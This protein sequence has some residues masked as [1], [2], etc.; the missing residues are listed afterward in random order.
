L[1]GPI[2]STLGNLAKLERL[3]LYSNQLS[4]AIPVE[5]GNLSGLERIWLDGNQLSDVVPLEVAELGGQIQY[6][7]GLT[8]CVFVP[9]G[10]SGLS[11]P[12]NQDYRDADL[13]DDGFICGIEIGR[14]IIDINHPPDSCFNPIPPDSATEVNPISVILSWQA[15]DPDG[16]AL[17]YAIEWGKTLGMWNE[18]DDLPSPTFSLADLDPNTPYYWQVTVEDEHG[19]KLECPQWMFTT[20][21]K[22][23]CDGFPPVGRSSTYQLVGSD[24]QATIVAQEVTELVGGYRVYRSHVVGDPQGLGVYNTC[25]RVLGEIEV[26][27]DWWYPSDPSIHGRDYWV[28][29]HPLCAQWG[30]VGSSCSWSGTLGGEWEQA[31]EQVLAYETVSV[32]FGTFPNVMKL[33][34]STY[35]EY[36][37]WHFIFWLDRSVGVVKMYDVQ[38]EST[39]VLVAHTPA[40]APATVYGQSAPVPDWASAMRSL[41]RIFSG[42]ERQ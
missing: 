1:D 19:A 24:D 28:P 26:A 6:S 13:D 34:S 31:F 18:T 42:K 23:L 21:S 8:E 38:E 14:I 32:P 4:G 37:D 11:M 22:G 33:R 25:D 36:G 9:P 20:G 27:T 2:P 17:T 40:P 39:I 29:P 12:N 16:D 5:L 35:D 3:Y 30:P 10:N 7:F 41:K 15:T